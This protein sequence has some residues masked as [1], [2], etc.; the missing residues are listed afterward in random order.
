[1][2]KHFFSFV[3]ILAISL[4][5]ISCNR[6]VLEKPQLSIQPI[7]L[8]LTKLAN[9][10]FLVISNDGFGELSWE[11]SDKP[12]WLEA[13][14]GSGKVTTGK[15]TVI[16]TANINQELGCYS[17][18]I[19][20]TSNGGNEEVSISLNISMWNKMENMP[21]ARMGH[22]SCV[23]DGKIYAIGGSGSG[24]ISPAYKKM[25][26][27]WTERNVVRPSYGCRS[28]YQEKGAGCVEWS[29][30]G[31]NKCLCSGGTV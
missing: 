31:E 30:T 29:A 7:S 6:T 8:S 20:I 19:N 28:L 24:L 2:K 9:S 18:T 17:G 26:A 12:D 25:E 1:M 11:I 22:S 4:I 27:Y 10:N 14:K 5:L 13:S 16:V 23:L 3:A 15:D 21:T